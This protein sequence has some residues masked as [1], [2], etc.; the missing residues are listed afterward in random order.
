MITGIAVGPVDVTVVRLDDPPATE[1]DGWEDMVEISI[2]AAGRVHA[3][4]MEDPP[5]AD[6]RLDR[7]GP[8][9]YRLRIHAAGRDIAYDSVVDE[10]VEKYLVQSWPA[11]P[12]SPRALSLSPSALATVAARRSNPPPPRRAFVTPEWETR[13]RERAFLARENLFRHSPQ[14]QSD[15]DAPSRQ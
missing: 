13:E 3:V 6:G 2:V 4:G 11:P 9:W 10:P 14:G 8:G 1:L 5:P 7:D 15:P 12:E